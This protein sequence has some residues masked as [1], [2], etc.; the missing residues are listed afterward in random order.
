MP[1]VRVDTT[2]SHSKEESGETQ[3]GK[4]VLVHIDPE[5]GRES[6]GHASSEKKKS[7]CL[8]GDKRG[9]QKKG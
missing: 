1:I 6:R 2:A 7:F 4:E 5:G 9:V 3:G 8:W